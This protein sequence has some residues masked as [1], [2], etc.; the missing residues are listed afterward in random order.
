[1]LLNFAILTLCL[2]VGTLGRTMYVKHQLPHFYTLIHSF[3]GPNTPKKLF[4]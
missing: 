2:A 4:K 3:L 1:M